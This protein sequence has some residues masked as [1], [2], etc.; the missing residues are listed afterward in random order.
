[1]SE[2][3]VLEVLA[4]EA[5]FAGL[6]PDQLG[7]LAA[8]GEHVHF[9][10]GARVL[11]A[12]GPASTFW[13]IRD[14]EVH[15]EIHT[16]D[17]GTVVIT[18][19]HDGDLLGVSWMAEPHTW[20]FDA[21]AVAETATVAFDTERLLETCEA[22]PALGFAVFRLFAGVARDRLQDARLQLLDLTGGGDG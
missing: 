3:T 17:R 8:C 15:V 5:T 6:S 21:T 12:G 20:T 19:L 4:E 11:T 16:G 7:A 13:L 10:A 2:P 14:G 22:D 9:P 18:S 1:M